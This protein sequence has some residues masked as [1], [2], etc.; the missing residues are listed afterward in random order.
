VLDILLKTAPIFCLIGLGFA[1]VKYQLMPQEA[2]QGLGRFV[3]YFT[4]PALIFS[5][6]IHMDLTEIFEPDFLIMYGAGSVLA[7][8]LGALTARFV[9]KNDLTGCGVKG[10]GWSVSNSA[11]FGLPVLLLVLPEPAT[12]AFS[13]GLIIENLIVF[14]I[15]LITIE[16]GQG[17][18]GGRS[19]WHIWGTVIKRV[20]KNPLIIAISAGFLGSALH[21]RP[22]EFLDTTF[23]MLAG[24]SATTALFVIGGSLVG[25]TLKG[26]V[27]DISSVIGGKLFLHPLC[28]ALASF[29]VPGIDPQFRLAAILMAAMPM[30][31]IYPIIGGNY[32]YRSLCASIL[33]GAT[34]GS[35][36]TIAMIMSFSH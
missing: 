12:V 31:S 19:V 22:P 23:S 8:A 24:A 10:L 25:T 9:S 4:L 27:V 13:M 17:T 7:F 18:Q 26:S 33:M 28:V 16:L 20:I 36:I 34:L 6:L 3:L 14:P 15:G 1:A 35:F 2:L 5:T 21:I 11:F 29:L 32:G 30:M